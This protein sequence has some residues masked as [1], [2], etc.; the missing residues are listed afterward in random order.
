MEHN[1]IRTLQDRVIDDENMLRT[2][3]SENLTQNDTSFAY[4]KTTV[5]ISV[6]TYF[7]SALSLLTIK[8]VSPA[9]SPV[10]LGG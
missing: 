1:N 7:Q 4:Y 2:E 9:V 3:M 8:T 5:L 10:L 6:T